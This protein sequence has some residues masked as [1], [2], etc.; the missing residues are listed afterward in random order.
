MQNGFT[1]LHIA[2]AE[3]QIH[4]WRHVRTGATS[5]VLSL[6]SWV[7]CSSL[8]D[9]KP[10]NILYETSRQAVR[11]ADFGE[12]RSLRARSAPHFTHAV[13]FPCFVNQILFLS[14]LRWPTYGQHG[15]ELPIACQ[16]LLKQSCNSLLKSCLWICRPAEASQSDIKQAS[17]H[18]LC[19]DSLVSSARVLA[20]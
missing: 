19:W 20:A 18:R 10:E 14:I 7:H 1:P 8:G 13:S 3:L 12:S 4:F 5:L 17:V 15:Q 16:Q 9:I 11:I 6:A 2:P